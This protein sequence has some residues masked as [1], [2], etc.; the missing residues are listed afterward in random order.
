ML[1]CKEFSQLA[2]DGLDRPLSLWER[3]SMTMHRLMCPA[4][5]IIRKQIDIM[6]NGCRYVPSDNPDEA[7]ESCVLPD[8]AKRRIKRIL[9]ETRKS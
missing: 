6:R 7:D 9:L 1:N 4:C 2:F 8:D 3:A 5:N